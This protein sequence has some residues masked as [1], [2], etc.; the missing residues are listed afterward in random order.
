MD[1]KNLAPHEAIEL[2]EILT[3][4]TLCATKSATMSGLVSDSELKT[5]L[6][7]DFSLSKQHISDINDLLQTT[8]EMYGR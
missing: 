5:L 4:K 8:Q 3:F 2:H 6:N 1:I 7:K